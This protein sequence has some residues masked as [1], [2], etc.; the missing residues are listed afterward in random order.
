M[1]GFGCRYYTYSWKQVLRDLKTIPKVQS[2]TTWARSVKQPVVL[3]NKHAY[4]WNPPPDM[5]LGNSNV[6]KGQNMKK[7]IWAGWRKHE[8]NEK[9]DCFRQDLIIRKKVQESPWRFQWSKMYGRIEILFTIFSGAQ[10]DSRVLRIIRQELGM[11]AGASSPTKYKDHEDLQN[12][13]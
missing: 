11:I 2:S 7:A 4:V 13:L 10:R 12:R 3:A 5:Y 1:G 6:S 9:R 8:R